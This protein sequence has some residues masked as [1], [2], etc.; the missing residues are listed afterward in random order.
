MSGAL[1]I[2]ITA[3]LSV[4]DRLFPDLDPEAALYLLSMAEVG[5][6]EGLAERKESVP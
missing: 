4:A 6:R 5:A 3:A 1:S 2:D